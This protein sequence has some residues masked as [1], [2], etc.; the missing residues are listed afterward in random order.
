[1][2]TYVC[3][4]KAGIQ[5]IPVTGGSDYYLVRFPFGTE[6]HDPEGMHEQVQP[7][8]ETAAYP[9]PRCGLIWPRHE[10]WA[11]LHALIYWQPGAYSEVRDRF[12]RDP[13]GLSTGY[14][15]TC[16]EDR[17]PS[18]G[19]QYLAKSWAMFVHPGTPIGLMVKHNSSSPVKLDLAEFKLSYT[20]D[21]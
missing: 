10:A 3:S 9:D 5:T 20:L 15:S 4:L 13:L 8:G 12:V 19:G 16:T 6:S 14:D 21:A 7:D 18:G 2:P 11:H 1:M 17:E